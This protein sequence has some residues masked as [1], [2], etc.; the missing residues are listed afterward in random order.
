M[1]GDIMI[2]PR[3]E[4]FINE[5]IRWV[6]DFTQHPSGILDIVYSVDDMSSARYV[7][8]L[9]NVSGDWESFTDGEPAYVISV[10]LWKI[11]LKMED[12]YQRRLKND[13]KRKNC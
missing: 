3:I 9:L 12:V 5:E 6:S 1:R 10:P 13:F 11:S 8:N 2:E 7:E 4:R